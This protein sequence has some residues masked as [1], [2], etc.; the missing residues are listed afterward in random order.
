ML[1][2]RDPLGLVGQTLD[3]QYRVDEFVGEGGFSVVYRGFH[4]GLGEIVAIKC[5]KLQT[6][7]QLG[8]AVVES[9]VRRFRDEGRILYRLSQGN[10]HIVRSIASGT[11]IAPVTGS[12]VPY[13]VLEWLEGHSLA[14]DFERR[15]AAAM[16][17]RSPN[18]AAILF[19]TAF[20]AVA[21]A[22]D[23]GVVHRDLNPGNIFLTQTREGVRAKVL[24]F[25]IA[26]IVSDHALELGP[27][28]ATIG[29]FRMFSPAYAAPEQ[30]DEKLGKAGPYTDVYTLA[31]VFVEALR[32][33]PAIDGE[34]LSTLIDQTLNPN[35]RPTPRTLGVEVSDALENVLGRALAISPE[36]RPQNAG[37]LWVEIAAA[38]KIRNVSL[39]HPSKLLKTPPPAQV[40]PRPAFGTQTVRMESPLHANAP[41]AIGPSGLVPSRQPSGADGAFS[42]TLMAPSPEQLRAPNAQ[43]QQQQTVLMQKIADPS[44]QNASGWAGKGNEPSAPQIFQSPPS[45]QMPQFAAP[46][47]IVAVAR[48]GDGSASGFNDATNVISAPKKSSAPVLILIG[49]IV[50]VVAG[51]AFAIRSRFHLQSSIAGSATSSASVVPT[52]PASEL[53]TLTPP[54]PTP[55]IAAQPPT[56]ASAE[57]TPSASAATTVADTTTATA[58]ATTDAPRPSESAA[59]KPSAAPSVASSDPNGFDSAAANHS[60]ATSDS[61]LVSCADAKGQRGVAHV[62]FGNDGAAQNVVVDPPLGGTPG[63]DCVASR[64]KTIAKAPKYVGAPVT[65]DHPFHVP[66]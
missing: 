15:R 34:N 33:E 8:S 19:S 30:F 20:E 27:R 6:S 12:L 62:T 38:L 44:A 54:E 51:G 43:Q 29:Q 59:P 55:T 13:T 52:S 14:Q 65:V 41:A 57:P 46:P 36:N 35:R 53:A 10:L 4:V 21:Y 26:K 64:Y 50:L 47:P 61:I 17:G 63:G 42:A 25:G 1:G 2:A 31:I 32:D 37:E 9:F 23:Q 40:A 66:K 18:E 22:H 58:T 39:P 56:T 7:Q 45:P 60:L 28:A 48:D 5:L 24:D 49:V 11:T 16:R 3:G